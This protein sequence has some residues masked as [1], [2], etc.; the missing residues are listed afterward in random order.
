VKRAASTLL[1][2]RNRELK[3]ARQLIARL[4]AS[5]HY[6]LSE[7]L[8]SAERMKS[9][10]LGETAHFTRPASLFFHRPALE[11]LCLTETGYLVTRDV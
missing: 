6:R 5:P 7:L 10:R 4:Q 1:R 2:I 8:A 3:A 11:P 9:T